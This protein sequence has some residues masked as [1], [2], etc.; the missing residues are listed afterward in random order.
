VT[1]QN[2]HPM[3]RNGRPG[4]FRVAERTPEDERIGKC[5][6]EK[7]GKCPLLL[8]SEKPGSKIIQ[9]SSFIRCM[10][11]IQSP[12]SYNYMEMFVIE[13]EPNLMMLSHATWQN[14]F[15]N[16]LAARRYDFSRFPFKLQ[17]WDKESKQWCLLT[18][19]CQIAAASF[20]VYLEKKPEAVFEDTRYQDQVLHFETKVMHERGTG[21]RYIQVTPSLLTKNPKE[22]EARQEFLRISLSSEVSFPTLRFTT[23]AVMQPPS[24]EF[25]CPFCLEGVESIPADEEIYSAGCGSENGHCFHRHCIEGWFAQNKTSCP[26]CRTEITGLI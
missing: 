9:M 21:T 22:G 14:H 2:N 8:E 26:I 12:I 7:Y 15:Q 19:D 23:P 4:I 6:S 5:Y 18:I 24:T 11:K 16:E 17:K 10:Q 13:G 20:L 3:S 1:E 25:N